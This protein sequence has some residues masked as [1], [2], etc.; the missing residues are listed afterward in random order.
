MPDQPTST[1]IAHGPFFSPERVVEI[2]FQCAGAATRPLLEDHPSYV[3]PSERV[4]AAVTYCLADFGIVAHAD[5]SAEL[6]LCATCGEPMARPSPACGN[7]ADHPRTM[8][9]STG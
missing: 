6:A 4:A 3:F 2:A 5:G 1:A 8:A 7:E 9:T